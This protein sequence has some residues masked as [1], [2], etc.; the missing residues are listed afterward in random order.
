MCHIL[1]LWLLL[2]AAPL[3]T[4]TLQAAEAEAAALQMRVLALEGE[5]VVEVVVGQASCRGTRLSFRN[6]LL[7][8]D[9]G[10]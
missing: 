3:V 5:E 9:Q 1:C 10:S 6:S 4:P 7:Y 2:W 8:C